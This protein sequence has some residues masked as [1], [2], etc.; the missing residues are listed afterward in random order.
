M[1]LISEAVGEGM[2]SMSLPV[3]EERSSVEGGSEGKV[4]KYSSTGVLLSFPPSLPPSLPSNAP[5]SFMLDEGGP[6][7]RTNFWE[8]CKEEGEGGGEGG[9]EGGMERKMCV[10]KWDSE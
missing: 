10:S 4:S 6:P 5:M 8:I 1:P 7:L 9:R 2:D 3:G